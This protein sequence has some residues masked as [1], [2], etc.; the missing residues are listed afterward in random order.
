[1]YLGCRMS[2]LGYGFRSSPLFRSSA[3]SSEPLP[4]ASAPLPAIQERSELLASTSYVL[5]PNAASGC[6][7]DA[8]GFRLDRL[9]QGLLTHLRDVRLPR[10]LGPNA[11]LLAERARASAVPDARRAALVGGQLNRPAAIRESPN[12][13]STACHAAAGCRRRAVA[14][15]RSVA[16]GRSPR[17]QESH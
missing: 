1:M 17:W 14:R 2:V 13:A 3:S 5:T 15:R 11:L 7:D 9:D 16:S 12:A 8:A 4:K 10:F 6:S